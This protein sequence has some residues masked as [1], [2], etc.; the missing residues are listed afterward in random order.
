MDERPL[1]KIRRI[2][3][4]G[5]TVVVAETVTLKPKK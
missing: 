3:V 2:D 4:S 1:K 5:S